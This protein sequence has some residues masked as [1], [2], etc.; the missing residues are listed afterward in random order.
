MCEKHTHT[1][2]Y[3]HAHT[4]ITTKRKHTQKRAHKIHKTLT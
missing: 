3:K 4:Q 1:G 2:T